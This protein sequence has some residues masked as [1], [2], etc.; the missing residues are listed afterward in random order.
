MLV[1]NFSRISLIAPLAN[2]AVLW[3]LPVLTILILTA[4]PLSAV[5]P[6]LSFLF[7]L[8]GLIL[9]KY[10]LIMVKYMAKIPYG[11]LEINYLWP[12]WL[13]VYYLSVIF[14]IIKLQRSKL[15]KKDVDDKI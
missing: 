12:G 14:I 9:T 4:L 7:F 8:P 1:Y 13:V 2:L 11:Y 15:L 3:V 6:G 10:I 5:L